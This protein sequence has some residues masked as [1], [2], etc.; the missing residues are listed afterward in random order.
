QVTGANDELLKTAIERLSQLDQFHIDESRFIADTIMLLK[1]IYPEKIAFIG[2]NTYQH[3]IKQGKE[4]ATYRYSLRQ[5]NQQAIF[6]L[7]QCF[8]G[9]YFDEVPFLN[10]FEWPARL[11][12]IQTK[13]FSFNQLANQL[14]AIWNLKE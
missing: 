6:I 5:P 2:E 13:Q 3:L 11:A 9:Q 8:L 1:L 10:W 12:E 4:Q 14:N 7:L